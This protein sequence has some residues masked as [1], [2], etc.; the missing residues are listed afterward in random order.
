M[1]ASIY[2]SLGNALKD[3]AA[4]FEGPSTE[5]IEEIDEDIQTI[6][7]VLDIESWRAN[8]DGEI[9]DFSQLL[10]ELVQ[11]NRVGDKQKCIEAISM[12][13]IGIASIE[14][15]FSNAK[16]SMEKLVVAIRDA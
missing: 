6:V 15:A 5:N 7:D 12:L 16:D 8:I 3:S 1:D 13:R 2:Q 10:S 14:S 4:V 9:K 11:A